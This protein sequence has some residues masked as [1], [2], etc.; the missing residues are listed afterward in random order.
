M[1]EMMTVLVVV[2]VLLTIALPSYSVLRLR[3][4]LKSY[5]NELVASVYLA[6][7]EA[8]KRN[9]PILMCISTDGSTCLGSGDW[10]QGWIVRDINP[11]GVVIRYQQML[12]LGMKLVASPNV[13]QMTFQPSG[14]VLTPTTITIC[15]E[16][17]SV[18]I[19]ERVV[20]ISATGRHR[21]ETTQAGCP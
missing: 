17:P 11:T 13:T 5:A 4:K 9:A 14:I 21:V 8:I 19:E 3:T 12:P 6:R 18:G 7:G 15:Q 10:D 16:S 2:G 20:T 1:V